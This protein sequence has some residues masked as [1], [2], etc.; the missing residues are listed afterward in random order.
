[1]SRYARTRSNAD[2][3]FITTIFVGV[4]TWT[5][6]TLIIT[7]APFILCVVAGLIVLHF[8]RR[9]VAYHHRINLRE[10]DAMDGLAFERYV[11]ALLQKK[12]FHHIR[13]T[14]KY[15][16]GVDIIAEKDGIR[17]G[18][19]VK[20]YS[21]LV[22]AAAVRQVVTG[23]RLYDCDRAMVITNST[24]STVAKRLATG[25]DCILIDRTQLHRLHANNNR[26]AIL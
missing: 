19:Q 17:W 5:H 20:R 4:T 21:G 3:S 6:W 15:D 18:I 12:G 26:G 23:L 16:L 22:K 2:M 13:L 24:Y 25:N 8:C 10:V 11:A 9:L 14:E 7:V 1:M